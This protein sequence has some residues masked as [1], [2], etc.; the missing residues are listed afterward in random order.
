MTH[1]MHVSSVGM[2]IWHLPSGA[3]GLVTGWPIL[4]AKS[5][6]QC[7]WSV[8]TFFGVYLHSL[9]CIYIL[10]SV[11]TFPGMYLHSLEC[12]YM[13]WSVPTFSG[14][15][16]HSLECTYILWSV[17]TFPGMYLHSL[18]CTYIPWNVPTFSGM[19]LHS[20][21]CTYDTIEKRARSVIFRHR[22]SNPG[23]SGESRVS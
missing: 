14:M 7:L 12:T 13:L 21:E 15:Y 10:W 22:D 17:P 6:G 19:Y 5:D 16:L 3:P 23:R 20:L 9:E 1:R 18:E 8:L 2:V 4:K 11:F